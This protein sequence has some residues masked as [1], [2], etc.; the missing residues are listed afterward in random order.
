V[1]KIAK[2]L[3]TTSSL[4]ALNL[5]GNNIGDEAADDIATVLFHNITFKKLYLYEANL[6][7]AGMI[8][9]A[10]SLQFHSSLDE[11]DMGGNSFGDGAAYK[12]AT[13]LS[14]SELQALGL[15][16]TV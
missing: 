12:I 3:K 10:K 8:K 5:G 14:H 2:A 6:K 11:L 4:R 7:T 9:I 16:V 15:K 13:V 1:I